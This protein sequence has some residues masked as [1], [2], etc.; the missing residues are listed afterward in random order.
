MERNC[1]AVAQADAANPATH[2]GVFAVSNNLA[3]C[4]EQTPDETDERFGSIEAAYS[5]IATVNRSQEEIFADPAVVAATSCGDAPAINIGC[6][7][8]YGCMDVFIS[9]EKSLKT[10]FYR[11]PT[12]LSKCYQHLLR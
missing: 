11:A 4:G 5:F 6:E 9:K 12:R 2:K 7:C 8:M 10:P 1:P 3:G